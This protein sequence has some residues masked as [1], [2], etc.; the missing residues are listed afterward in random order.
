MLY[1]RKKEL[2]QIIIPHYDHEKDANC[3]S[4]PF[5]LMRSLTHTGAPSTSWP[6]TKGD[7][8]PPVKLQNYVAWTLQNKQI[9][10]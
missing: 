5:S 6:T 4:P 3:I 2:L 1:L 8:I 10:I 9:L 7:T